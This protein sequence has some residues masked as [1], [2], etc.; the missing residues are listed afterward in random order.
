MPRVTAPRPRLGRCRRSP[1]GG[2]NLRAPGRA[3]LR[4]RP[5]QARRA[6]EIAAV[7]NHNLLLI[8]PPGTGKSMLAERLPGLLRPQTQREALETAALYSLVGMQLPAWKQRPFRSPH[9][10]ASV[11]A[12][13]SPTD[14]I[15]LNLSAERT[16][17]TCCLSSEAVVRHFSI[18]LA[19]SPSFN[20][21]HS[22]LTRFGAKCQ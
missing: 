10:T 20:T 5:R 18:A 1:G 12:I 15:S 8:G 13:G 16:A 22:P 14:S 11:A 7:G 9:H 3:A 4:A 17:S 21:N 19:I 2:R 6:L